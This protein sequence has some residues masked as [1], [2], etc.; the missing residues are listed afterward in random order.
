MTTPMAAARAALTRAEVL[1]ARR[2]RPV[3]SAT[4]ATAHALNGTPVAP[5]RALLHQTAQI[6]GFSR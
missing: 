1:M 5:A 3:N 4:N 2:L 6:T